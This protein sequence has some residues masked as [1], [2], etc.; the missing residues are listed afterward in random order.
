MQELIVSLLFVIAVIL[1]L[2]YIIR[3]IVILYIPNEYLT[4]E[5][6]QFKNKFLKFYKRGK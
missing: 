1:F 2:G 5:D 3:I 6:L 4:S